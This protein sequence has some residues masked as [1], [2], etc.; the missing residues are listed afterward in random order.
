VISYEGDIDFITLASMSVATNNLLLFGS[1]QLI[2]QRSLGGELVVGKSYKHDSVTHRTTWRVS[3]VRTVRGLK[4]WCKSTVGTVRGLK[5][6]CKSTV[7]TVRGLKWWCKST[8]GTVRGLKW[9][10][11]STVGTVRGLKWWCKST[12]GTVR[13]LAIT[14]YLKYYFPALAG[15]PERLVAGDKLHPRVSIVGRRSNFKG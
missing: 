6:W 5:W 12:V 3:T 11:K 13:G 1:T 14:N 7:G 9:W 4:W 2:L 8:V 10:G 15:E